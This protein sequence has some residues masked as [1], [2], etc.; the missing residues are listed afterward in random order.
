MDHSIKHNTSKSINKSHPSSKWSIEEDKLLTSLAEDPCFKS[1]TKKWKEI[2]EHFQGKNA[3]QCL[4][5][6]YR[7]KRGII[8]GKWTKEE[9]ENIINYV[10]KHGFKWSEISNV[11]KT[12]NSKQ[13]RDR[14]INYLNKEIN[15]E[16]FT[17]EEDILIIESISKVGKKWVQ[18]SK[19]LPGRSPLFIKNRYYYL[20]KHGICNESSIKKH[21][22]FHIEKVNKKLLNDP[23]L[24][25]TYNKVVSDNIMKENI[26]S[27]SESKTFSISNCFKTKDNIF[28]DIVGYNSA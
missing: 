24:N 14:F 2:S 28:S 23:N 6:Y 20:L 17:K 7:V 1:L 11:I 8:K 19:Y 15:K 21:R 3:K 5:R 13:I 26:N 27:S 22:I 16:S 9:D 25:L 12:R 10:N 18:L 4:S